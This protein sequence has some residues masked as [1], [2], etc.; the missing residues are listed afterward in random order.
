MI[1][2]KK[3]YSGTGLTRATG[4][5]ALVFALMVCAIFYVV[6]VLDEGSVYGIPL[7]MAVV[8]IAVP[9]L[10]SGLVFWFARA[11]ERH[12]WQCDDEE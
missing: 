4:F 7:P 8:T 9:T 12:G 3:P 10:L 1:R 2:W 11:L 6:L 5:A